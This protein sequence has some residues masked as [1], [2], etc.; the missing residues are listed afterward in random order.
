[1]ILWNLELTNTSVDPIL[2]EELP[3]IGDL[4]NDSI[5][6]KSKNR[7]LMINSS[8]VR[9]FIT[10]LYKGLIFEIAWNQDKRLNIIST[11][12]SHFV[13][14]ENV[15]VN[16]TLKDIKKLKKIEISK[17]NG[18]GYSVMLESGWKAAFCVD[19]KCTG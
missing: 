4:I 3:A 12:D 15:K 16:M 18:W 19:S 7:I 17:I 2:I 9:P 5:I 8:D 1:L 11:S 14:E 6:V 13:T 10:V